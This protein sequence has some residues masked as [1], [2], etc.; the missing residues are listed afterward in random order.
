MERYNYD[1]V[2]VTMLYLKSIYLLFNIINY[3][4]NL[5]FLNFKNVK[6]LKNI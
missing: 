1:D 3:F 5:K 6:L 4:H 2:T